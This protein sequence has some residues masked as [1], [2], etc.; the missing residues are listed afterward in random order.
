MRAAPRRSAMWKWSRTILPGYN[1]DISRHHRWTRGDWQLLPY[2]FSTKPGV[3]AVTRWKMVD[4][5][6]RSLT[7]IFWILASIAGCGHCCRRGIAALVAVLH[8]FQHVHRANDDP[9][10]QSRAYGHEPFTQ[11]AFPG[12]LDGH[13][14]W[15]CGY[16]PA[17][18]L[19]RQ[20]GLPDGTMQLR[21]R[22]TA[23][24]SRANICL[25]WRAAAQAKTSSP[26]T[27]QLLHA[28]DVAS[29][30]RRTGCDWS[31][32]SLAHSRA[33]MHRGPVRRDLVSLAGD[34]LAGQ[35]LCQA[36]RTI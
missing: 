6:R 12:H 2:L 3:T 7:P 8:D 28:T 22:S 24:L 26:D 31:C 11:G 21:A 36:A 10:H 27:L 23:C 35:P 9:V 19:H 15:C 29:S 33:W 34:C 14:C 25:E 32:R 18:H 13:I 17:H 4:N 30:N 16:C 20:H 1:V 5:L